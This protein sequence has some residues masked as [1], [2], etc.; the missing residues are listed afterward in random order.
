MNLATQTSALCLMKMYFFGCTSEM[1]IILLDMKNTFLNEVYK[2]VERHKPNSNS[3]SFLSYDW[4]WFVYD[5][6]FLDFKG[7]C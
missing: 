6:I 4:L 2:L 1:L 7:L 3:I 5:S